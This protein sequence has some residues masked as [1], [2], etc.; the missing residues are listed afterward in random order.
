[1]IKCNNCN[2]ET[3]I[4]DDSGMIACSKC[5]CILLIRKSAKTDIKDSKAVQ[6]D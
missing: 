4:I 3:F 6:S 5:H 2:N 1:M